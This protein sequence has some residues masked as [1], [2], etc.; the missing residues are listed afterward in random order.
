MERFGKLAVK[1][2]WVFGETVLLVAMMLA[3]SWF[4]SVR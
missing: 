2:R 1:V 4:Y 3:A